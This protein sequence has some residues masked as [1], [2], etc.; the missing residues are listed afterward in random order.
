MD[1]NTRNIFIEM[2]KQKYLSKDNSFEPDFLD[3]SVGEFNEIALD[4]LIS[5]MDEK[6]PYNISE[7]NNFILSLKGHFPISANRAMNR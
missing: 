6:I 1:K 7:Y 3:I 5:I 2:L 4:C